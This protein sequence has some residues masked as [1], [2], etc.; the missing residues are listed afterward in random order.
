[1]LL[2][3]G[4]DHWALCLSL[5]CSSPWEHHCCGWALMTL[6]SPL[7]WSALP[8]AAS[9]GMITALQRMQATKRVV[10][11]ETVF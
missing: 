9:R 2:D 5:A 6:C 3:A 7:P 10:N 1:M 4:S 11:M 8:L